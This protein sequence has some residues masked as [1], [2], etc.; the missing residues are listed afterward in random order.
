MARPGVVLFKQKDLFKGHVIR[1]KADIRLNSLGFKSDVTFKSCNV[2]RSWGIQLQPD[3]LK[4]VLNDMD[5]LEKHLRK[6]EDDCKR[7]EN[8]PPCVRFQNII[9]KH[10]CFRLTRILHSQNG[11]CQLGTFAPFI[12]PSKLR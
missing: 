5:D 7:C 12:G 2:L 1:M 3:I 11:N 10:V 4:S 6:E 8:I 9:S